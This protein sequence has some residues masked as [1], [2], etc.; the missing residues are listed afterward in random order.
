VYDEAVFRNIIESCGT[1]VVPQLDLQIQMTWH[2]VNDI[3]LTIRVGYGV[4]ANAT[5]GIPPEPQG[6]DEGIPEQWYLFQTATTDPESDDLYYFWDWG[7]GDSTGW[8]GPYDSGQDSKVNHAWDD[9]GTY[10]VKV[11]VKDAW[12]AE[13]DWSTARTIEIDCCQGTVGNVDGSGIVDGA[14]LSVLIDHLFISLNALDCV[15]EGDLNHSGA[16]E[17]DPMDVDGADLSIMI[18]HLF[19]TLDDLLPCP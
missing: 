3:E 4:G 13:T 14:D 1:R 17:P 7:D 19:I 10:E 16:P 12:D 9:N 15:K 18:D 11:K 8:I 2:S 5:P 6:P